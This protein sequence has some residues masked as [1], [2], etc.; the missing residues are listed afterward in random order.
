MG[1]ASGLRLFADVID[2]VQ[3]NVADDDVRKEIYSSLITAFESFD[4]DE[5][6]EL[7]GIDAAYDE[8]YSEKY[9]QREDEEEEEE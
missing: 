1:W 8:A 2:I 6:G 5:A 9:P 3:E 7:V 4:M